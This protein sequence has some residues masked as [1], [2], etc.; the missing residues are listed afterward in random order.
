MTEFANW[1]TGDGSAQIDSVAK[2]EAQMADMVH[3]LE[4]R[5]DV[6]RYAWFTGRMSS[7]PHFDSLLGGSGQLTDLAAS[8]WRSRGKPPRARRLN[9]AGADF[10]ARTTPAAKAVI[11]H[12]HHQRHH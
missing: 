12:R 2:Q 1:H 6:F 3:T 10:H 9:R 11:Q 4:S 8:I 5:S 7:D